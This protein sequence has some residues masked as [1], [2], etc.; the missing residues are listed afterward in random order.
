MQL[1]ERGGPLVSFKHRYSQTLDC[2][3]TKCNQ[4]KGKGPRSASSIDILR[5]L[6]ASP[7]NA[8]DR[9][10][11]APGQLQ[12]LIFSDLCIT[13]KCNRQ[14]GEGP[15]S[16]SS[17]DI[18]RPLIASPPNTIDRKGRASSS[19]FFNPLIA[20]LLNAI[21]RKGRA[22]SQLQASIFSDLG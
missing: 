18:L 19:I 16:A 8:I 1:T 11:R 6:I 7:T 10:G 14:K 17:I 2:I 9:K 13:D 4:Q 15:Q 12:A 5:P 3:A 21:N 20:S 22:P